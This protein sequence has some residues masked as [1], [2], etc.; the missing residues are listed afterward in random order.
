[1]KNLL[2]LTAL[3]ILFLIINTS[4]QVQSGTWSVK[5]GQAGYNLHTNQGERATT[6]SVRFPTP[7]ENKPKVALSVTQI[8]ADK[9][10]N[11]RYNVEAISISR[12]GFTI[13]IRTWADSKVF[14]ISGY[15]I[16]HE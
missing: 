12:D 7:F 2:S 14:S 8:D 6:I 13:K 1:M 16:A 4:A 11:Q 9:N 15:W 5:E 3:L 10:A